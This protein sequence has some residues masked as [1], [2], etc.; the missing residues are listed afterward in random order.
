[1]KKQSIQATQR[2]TLR[3]ERELAGLAGFRG[4]L[5]TMK[6]ILNLALII[7]SK[8]VIKRFKSVA[9]NLHISVCLETYKQFSTSGYSKHWL[10]VCPRCMSTAMA[11]HTGNFPT[12]SGSLPQTCLDPRGAS[13]FGIMMPSQLRQCSESHLI[14]FGL[15]QSRG[16]GR[17]IYIYT[18]VHIHSNF[19]TSS[20]W[21]RIGYWRLH[22]R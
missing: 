22:E 3:T 16:V 1:M 10:V 4:L 17:D 2:C 11:G 20:G 18:F 12:I 7:L 15:N 9:L 6:V 13:C 19:V 8:I 21:K 5:H 14:K